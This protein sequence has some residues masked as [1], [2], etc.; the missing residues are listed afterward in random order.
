[1]NILMNILICTDFGRNVQGSCGNDWDGIPLVDLSMHNPP[2]H[3]L[4]MTFLNLALL[5]LKFIIQLI[6]TSY[7]ILIIPKIDPLLYKHVEAFS[8]IHLVFESIICDYLTSLRYIMYHMQRTFRG[9]DLQL[10]IYTK[11]E[12]TQTNILHLRFF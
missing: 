5:H 8:D 3:F 11:T 4:E 6:D 9:V 10:D 1:M 12:K 2:H 7:A